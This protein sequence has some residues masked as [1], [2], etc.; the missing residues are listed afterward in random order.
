MLFAWLFVGHLAGDF[1]F[2]NRW[3]AE[4]KTTRWLP[5]LVHSFVYTTAVTV[6][7]MAVGG[8]TWRGGI[9]Y[10]FGSPCAGP[11]RICKLV[12]KKHYSIPGCALACHNN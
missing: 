6:C 1:L 7:A 11:A 8:V 4:G 2:Q 5:L 12:G 3:M 9:I 10:L